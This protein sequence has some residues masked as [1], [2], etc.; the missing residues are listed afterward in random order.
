MIHLV[1]AFHSDTLDF[2]SVESISIA[3]NDMYGN[4]ESESILNGAEHQQSWQNK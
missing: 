3:A 1:Y 4:T 2:L